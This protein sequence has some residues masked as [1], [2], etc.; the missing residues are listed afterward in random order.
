[1]LNI[2]D[3]EKA[4]KETQREPPGLEEEN[5]ELVQSLKSREKIVSRKMLLTDQ[6]KWELRPHWIYHFSYDLD[7]VIFIGE[8][9][10]KPAWCGLKE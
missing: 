1:M 6:I 9:E 5:Q 10:T 8:V 7:K 4:G 2:R 3:E